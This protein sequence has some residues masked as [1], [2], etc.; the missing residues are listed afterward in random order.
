MLGL[1]PSTATAIT[2][3]MLFAPAPSQSARPARKPNQGRVPT[4]LS[5]R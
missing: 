2:C 1:R 5:W 4:K 3:I